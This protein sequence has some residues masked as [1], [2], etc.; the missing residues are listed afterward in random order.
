MAKV[1]RE[2]VKKMNNAMHNG[3]KVDLWHLLNWNEK[4]AELRIYNPEK[5]AY[6]RATM[7]Y[8]DKTQNYKHVGKEPVINIAKWLTDGQVATSYGMGKLFHVGE[9][10]NR[11]MFSRIQKLTADYTPEKILEM[12]K[13]NGITLDDDKHEDG[14]IL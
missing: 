8:R 3:W 14:R 10:Q 7:Y 2:A 4:Q 11:A 6:I 12:A 9:V 1:T 5:T 13:E